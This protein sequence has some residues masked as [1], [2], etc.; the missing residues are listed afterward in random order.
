MVSLIWQ[1][2]MEAIQR[3]SYEEDYDGIEYWNNPEKSGW[4]TKQGEVIKTWRRRW[5]V[6]KQGK[7]FWFKDSNVNSRL[8]KPRGVISVGANCLTVKCAQDIIFNQ[9][10]PF[11]IITNT[12]DYDTLYFLADSVKEKNEWISS[13]GRSIIQHSPSLIGNY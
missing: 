10:F 11:Q 12:F 9:E 3:S 7:L 13:I 1:A 8:V 2:A 6:L 5:F 4:L